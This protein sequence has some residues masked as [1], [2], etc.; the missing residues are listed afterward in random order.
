MS[1]P[2]FPLLDKHFHFPSSAASWAKHYQ[3]LQ[4]SAESY[5]ETMES[6]VNIDSLNVSWISDVCC[7]SRKDAISLVYG[8]K[9]K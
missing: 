4:K 5:S 7:G 6:D 2:Q 9:G 1:T 8:Y 3:F